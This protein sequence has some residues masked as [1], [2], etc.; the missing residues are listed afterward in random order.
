MSKLIPIALL[1]FFIICPAMAAEIVPIFSNCGTKT[2]KKEDAEYCAINYDYNGLPNL[3]N[4]SCKHCRE[5]LGWG[6]YTR[7]SKPSNAT[8][9]FWTQE[10]SDAGMT[11]PYD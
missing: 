1:S 7:Y 8:D 6:E 5:S 2:C 3:Q 4:S 9:I 10:T 11:T